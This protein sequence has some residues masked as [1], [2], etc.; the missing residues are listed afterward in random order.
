MNPR[1]AKAKAKGR[2][3]AWHV[4]QVA[5]HLPKSIGMPAN[6]GILE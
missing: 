1:V 6:P 4:R 2:A 5:M 3:L